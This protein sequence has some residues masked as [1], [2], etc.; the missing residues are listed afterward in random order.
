ML[1]SWEYLTGHVDG[2][3][4]TDLWQTLWEIYEL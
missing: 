1:L 4:T 2:I 3:G